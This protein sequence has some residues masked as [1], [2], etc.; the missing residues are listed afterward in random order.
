MHY[1]NI[2]KQIL[3]NKEFN[4]LN[5]LEHHGISRYDHS[6]RVS[7]YS[8][9]ITK[10]LGLDYE[11]VARGGLLH[12]FFLSEK[13]QKK[14]NR[15]CSFFTHPKKALI[16][17][18]N[19]FDLNDKEINIIKSH[20]FPVNYTLP[21]YRESFIVSIV[22]K[23]IALFEFILKLGYK[24]TYFFNLFLIIIMNFIK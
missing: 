15:V 5:D 9:K 16:K 20:M 19:I 14:I 21:K 6:L 3:N 8:Y 23:I 2:V 18:S 7:Y 24:L 12:D 22:D 17:S 11:S 13:K 4:K 1:Y 10:K